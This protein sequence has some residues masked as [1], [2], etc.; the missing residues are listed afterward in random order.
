MFSGIVSDVGRVVAVD[1]ERGNTRLVIEGA[2]PRRDLAMGASVACHGVCLTVMKRE[3]SLFSLFS[4]R[5]RF[6][7]MASPETVAR[8]DIGTWRVGRSIHL[9]GALRLGDAIGGHLMFGHVDGLAVVS[10]LQAEGA[11]LRMAARLS[12]DI[13]PFMAVRGSV[14]ID[15]VALTITGVDKARQQIEWVVVPQTLAQT[16]LGGYR[17]GDN[18]HVEVDMLAR[19]ARA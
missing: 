3:R 9:E 8:T 16:L 1:E 19:Y 15:G 14:A 17:V 18:V 5:R 13:M 6:C 7:V 11:S 2:L 4:G 10:R 12:Q